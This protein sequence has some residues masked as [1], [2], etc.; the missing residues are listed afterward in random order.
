MNADVGKAIL[1]FERD[2]TSRTDTYNKIAIG[3]L[4]NDDVVAVVSTSN[5]PLIMAE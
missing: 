3:L 5:E 4:L 2:L 1:S